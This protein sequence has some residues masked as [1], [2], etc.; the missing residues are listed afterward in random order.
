MS[1]IPFTGDPARA[2]E[3]VAAWSASIAARAEA[4]Q[5]LAAQVAELHVSATGAGGAIE[6]TVGGSGQVT[7][8]RLEAGVAELAPAELAEQIL[9]TMRRAQGRIAASVSGIAAGTVGRDTETAR[10]VVESYR[11]RFP[12]QPGEQGAGE[13]RARD[14]YAAVHADRLRGFGGGRGPG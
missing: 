6:V 13:P 3:Q 9:A 8:L 7:G 5:Q 11:A 2:E 12:E 1:S 4:A 10:A 14:P